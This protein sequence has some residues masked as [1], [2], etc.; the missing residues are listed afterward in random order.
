M[1][2]KVKPDTEIRTE[3]IEE[4]KQFSSKDFHQTYARPMFKR[5]A[6]LIH[7]NVEDAGVH[8]QF[9]SERKHPVFHRK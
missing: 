6:Y 2:T 4:Q 5:P 1:V 9:S 3:I 7:K 8:N